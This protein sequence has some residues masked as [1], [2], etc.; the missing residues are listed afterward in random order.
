MLGNKQGNGFTAHVYPPPNGK[1]FLLPVFFH[2]R[3]KLPGPCFYSQELLTCIF[4]GSSL[5]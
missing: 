3:A 4:V 1:Y 2:G 5:R